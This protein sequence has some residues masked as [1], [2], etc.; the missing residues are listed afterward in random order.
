[1]I[2]KDN[3]PD[4]NLVQWR[5][6]VHIFGNRPSPAVANY[7]LN[8]AARADPNADPCAAQF[9]RKN[10]YVDDGCGTAATVAQAVQTLEESRRVLSR[11]NI[12]LHKIVSSSPEV[13]DAFPAS[14]RADDLAVVDFDDAPQQRTLGVAWDIKNDCFL[15]Q[16]DL[17]E[18]PFT[19]RGILSVVNS[20][21]DPIGFAAP[22]VLEGK[23][24][25]R[26]VISSC[27]SGATTDW[28]EPLPETNLARW[29]AWKE[30]LVALD[31][32][33]IPRGFIPTHFGPVQCREL[34][35]FSDASQDLQ[36]GA[37]LF[38]ICGTPH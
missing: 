15:I 35:V 36:H 30:T 20:V 24:I 32:L 3:N 22:T 19:K 34:H 26:E 11:F 6:R 29:T 17:P 33:K 12:R 1:M 27:T 18:R 10:F 9:V 2:D 8:H 21:F 4:N 28:D 25:Q 7:G 23:L 38:K 5:S 16:V 31:Q 37:S 13:L 14:E